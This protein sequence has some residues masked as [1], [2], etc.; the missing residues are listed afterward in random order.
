MKKMLLLLFGLAA[1]WSVAAKVTLP[2]AIGSN[3]VLQQ[4]TDVKLWGWADPHAAVK[5]E[6]SWG[7]KASA[8]SDGEGRWEVT[9]KTPAGSYEP[10]RITVA[11]GDKRVLDNVLI[12][13]VWFCSGQSNMDMPL[14]GYWNGLIEGGN[15]VIACADAQRDRIRFL[16]VAYSQGYTPQDRVPG[17]WN[18]FTTATAARC[19]A[20][21]YFFAEMLS[22]ALNVPV[23]VI[24]SSWGGSRIE[25]WTPRAA[26]ETYPDID[27]DEK[28]VA[29]L[30]DYMRPMAMYNAMVYP[31][32]RYTVCGFLWYQGESNIGCHTE[33]AARMADMVAGWRAQWGLGELPFYF[34][35]IAPFNYWGSDLSAFLREAQCRAQDVIPN[36]GMVSTNDL[37]EPYEWCN[38]HPANKHDIG[39]RLACMALNRTYGKKAVHCDS[40]RFRSAEFA[41]GKAVVSLDNAEYGFNRLVGIEGFELCGSDGVFH[42]ADVSVDGQMRL[43]ISSKEVPEPSAVRYCFRNFRIGN[44]ANSWGLPVI[45]FRTD[46]FQ[47]RP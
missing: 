24:D 17:A 2:D 20:T 33:Y 21:A 3:M 22:R 30:P 44:L 11:S 9:L 5:V 14:G 27:L 15:E 38:I 28:A 40:P 1:V 45:P 29:E 41:D 18:E 12:G 35:E 16:K 13:E 31:L 46:D 19:S 7:A 47:P 37:V 39:Y 26:L 36:S 23:G 8:K 4:N 34:V 32:T 25:C 6:A 10:Q 42:P 43:V